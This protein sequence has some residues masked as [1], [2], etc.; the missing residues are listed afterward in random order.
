M[1]HGDDILPPEQVTHQGE[2]G[3]RIVKRSVKK[4]VKKGVKK[5]VKTSVN[6]SV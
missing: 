4:G 3:R 6:K 2:S 1:I 5:S